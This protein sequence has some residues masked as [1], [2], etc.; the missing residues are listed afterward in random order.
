MF[1]WWLENFVGNLLVP[2]YPVCISPAVLGLEFKSEPQKVWETGQSLSLQWRQHQVSIPRL[3]SVILFVCMNIQ[4]LMCERLSV[5]WAVERSFVHLKCFSKYAYSKV[6]VVKKRYSP[7]L[8]KGPPCLWVK[9]AAVTVT[10]VPPVFH[11]V[12]SPF[13]LPAPLDTLLQVEQ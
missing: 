4:A 3:E 12:T 2:W 9:S 10:V 1:R 6:P 5:G 11:G 7:G 8:P 13:T